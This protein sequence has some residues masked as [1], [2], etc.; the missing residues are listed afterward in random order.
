MARVAS[1]ERSIE[2]YRKLGFGVGNTFV[3]VG[4]SAPTW[5]RLESGQA[6]LMVTLADEPVVASQQAVLFYLYYDDVAATREALLAKGFE[7]GPIEFP[8]Y[9][10]RGEFRFVDPDGYALMVTHT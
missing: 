2:F 3:P 8:F 6:S 7:P 9:A 1:V 10:P 5:A 4:A